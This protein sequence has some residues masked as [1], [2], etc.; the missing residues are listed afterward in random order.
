MVTTVFITFKKENRIA[1]NSPANN[2]FPYS[3]T[4]PKCTRCKNKF[5][6]HDVE[7]VY[8]AGTAAAAEAAKVANDMARRRTRSFHKTPETVNGKWKPIK[9]SYWGINDVIL[10][11]WFIYQNINLLFMAAA[12]AVADAAA[13][14]WCICCSLVCLSGWMAGCCVYA[15]DLWSIRK[16]IF[17]HQHRTVK[18]NSSRV[19]CRG[20]CLCI[21]YGLCFH[22]FFSSAKSFQ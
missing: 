20:F 18:Q 17:H 7:K 19:L 3:H 9:T 8:R 15:T 21:I 16:R 6:F 10:S 11:L 22:F 5:S 2:I 1:V 4:H 13:T 12:D 14:G